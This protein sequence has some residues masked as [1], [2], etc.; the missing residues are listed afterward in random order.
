MMVVLWAQPSSRDM[1]YAMCV[2]A[3]SPL[4]SASFEY[5]TMSAEASRTLSVCSGA[6]GLEG[7]TRESTQVSLSRPAGSE[8]GWTA[9]LLVCEV[10]SK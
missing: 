2:T 9:I 4:I 8:D 1:R 5:Q 10:E 7:G 6:E 3:F